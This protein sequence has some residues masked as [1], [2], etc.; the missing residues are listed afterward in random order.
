[1]ARLTIVNPVAEAQ[2]DRSDAARIVPAPRPDTLDGKTVALF[3]NGKPN[4]DIAL[5]HTRER[6]AE[7]YTDVRFV[8]VFGEKG[9]LNRYASPDQLDEMA[10]TC[11][12]AVLTTAD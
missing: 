10:E 3:W 4:G 2:T 7:A 5:E 12:V 1:M 6:L 9:G 8:D 11:D